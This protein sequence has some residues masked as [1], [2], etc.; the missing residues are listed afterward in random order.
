MQQ[1]RI[2]DITIDAVIERDGPWRRPQ[3]FFPAYDDAVFKHHLKTMEPEVFDAASGLMVI[4]YQTFVV[5]TPHRT[6]LVDTCTG[7]NA[8][9]EARQRRATQEARG[10]RAS[11]QQRSEDQ[12]VAPSNSGSLPSTGNSLR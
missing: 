9:R 6:I 2:G 8:P 10:N 7:E 4:T 1:L 12:A 3:D 11:D 5:R